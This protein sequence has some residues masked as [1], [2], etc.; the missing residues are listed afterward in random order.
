MSRLPI[1]LKT[2]DFYGQLTMLVL[3]TFYALFMKKGLELTYFSLGIWNVMSIVASLIRVSSERPSG[4]RIVYILAVVSLLS[5]GAIA[6]GSEGWEWFRYIIYF[7]AAPLLWIW[8]LV[9]TY[10]EMTRMHIQFELC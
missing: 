8:Y 10:R 5:S 6:Y 3:P 9:I 1:I 4:V 7:F 2:V